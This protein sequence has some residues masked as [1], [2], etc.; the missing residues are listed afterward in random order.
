MKTKSFSAALDPATTLRVRK[1][2]LTALLE[3]IAI[4]EKSACYLLQLSIR[5]SVLLETYKLE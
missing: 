3:H 1:A 4:K 2:K 5:K